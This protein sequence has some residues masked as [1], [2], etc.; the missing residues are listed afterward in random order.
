[1]IIHKANII[2]IHIPKNG[3]S[4]IKKYLS[5][6]FK[7]PINEPYL[8]ERFFEIKK[9]KPNCDFNKFNK[10]AIIRN[11]YDR[12]IS[13]YCYLHGYE[14]K[15]T[16]EKPN[17]EDFRKWIKN[18]WELPRMWLLDPQYTWIDKTFS[19]LKFENL[20]K[21]LNNFFKEKVNLSH[22]KKSNRDNYLK[23][24]DEQTIDV[25]NNKYEKDFKIFKYKKL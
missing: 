24:Y 7:V 25:V 6:R 11:P 13:W 20:N 5:K 18:P 19:I 14:L 12:M 1:M 2:F 17:I 10:F 15:N 4:S 23:Y 3:G 8:H 21:D 22:L 9:N 16:N